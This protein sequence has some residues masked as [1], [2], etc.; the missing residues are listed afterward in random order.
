MDALYLSSFES[1]SQHEVISDIIRRTSTNRTDVREVVLRDLD[2][3]FGRTVLDL[4]CGFG[5]MTE[6]LAARV[7]PDALIT[8]IDV[9]PANEAPYLERVASTGRTGR[10]VCQCLD[11]RLDWPDASFDVVVASYALYFFPDVL[12]EVA[13]VLS[14]RGVFL[15][16]THTE[17]SCV[18]LMRA[19]GLNESN[20]RLVALIRRFSAETAGPLLARWFAEVERVDYRNALTFDA[21]HDDD[22]LTY[23]RFK[24]PLLLRD[25]APGGALPEPLARTARATLSR[26][27]RVVLEKDDAA[28]RCKRPQCP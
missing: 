25:P 17:R 14:S 28:F 8:G 12:P 27:G 3:S 4:G 24:L 22:F 13:R 20:S 26:Q 18:D 10:F 1:P 23:L 5:F 2:L 19:T 6:A 16:V 9:C 21:A 11:R 7:A 15:A